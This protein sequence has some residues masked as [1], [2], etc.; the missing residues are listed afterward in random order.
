VFSPARSVHHWP[1]HTRYRCTVPVIDTCRTVSRVGRCPCHKL[2]AQNFSVPGGFEN[3]T[4]VGSMCVLPTLCKKVTGKFDGSSAPLPWYETRARVH[5][6]PLLYN[7]PPVYGEW[8]AV[9]VCAGGSKQLIIYS[10]S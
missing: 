3:R 1:A 6:G 2:S 10:L 5:Q 4:R 9:L 7:Q 8:L